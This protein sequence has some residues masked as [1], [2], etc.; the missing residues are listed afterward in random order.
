M[1]MEEINFMTTTLIAN[2]RKH[3]EL[4]PAEHQHK[5]TLPPAHEGYIDS[6]SPKTIPVTPNSTQKRR[7]R[8]FLDLDYARYSFD[9]AVLTSSVFWRLKLIRLRA[10]MEEK[11]DSE[12]RPC[13]EDVRDSKVKE[14]PMAVGADNVPR[15]S[16]AREEQLEE[17]IFVVKPVV[18]RVE[19]WR[20]V[21]PAV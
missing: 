4:A 10:E 14:D 16:K 21:I 11:K 1:D 20:R 5:K 9:S 8:T 13:K 3:E 6:K 7:Q 18:R 15:E 2:Q 12:V 19:E 17:V